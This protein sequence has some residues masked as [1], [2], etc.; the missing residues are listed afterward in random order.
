[1]RHAPSWSPV[2]CSLTCSRVLNPSSPSAPAVLLEIPTECRNVGA[3]GQNMGS[4]D[5]RC[6]TNNSDSAYTAPSHTAPYDGTGISAITTPF[7]SVK[8]TL[9]PTQPLSCARSAA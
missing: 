2:R 5:E 1:M 3:Y 7:S 4:A 6:V 9:K 8:E